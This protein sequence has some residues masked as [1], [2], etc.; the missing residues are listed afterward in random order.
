MST[1][2]VTRTIREQVTD[3]L[4][5]EVL[6]GKYQAG[7]PLRE[8]EVA[9]R[10]GVSRGPVRDAFL[11]LSQEGLLTYQ[12]NRGVTVRQP[13]L[14]EHQRLIVSLRRQIECYC[15][16]YGLERVTDEDLQLIA[17]ALKDLKLACWSEDVARV[18]RCDLQFHEAVLAACGGSQFLPIW[19]GLCSQMLLAYSRLATFDQVYEEHARIMD[20]LVRRSKP[21]A[22]AALRAN[23][24]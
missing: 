17:Q 9:R 8:A 19:R 22:I 4:R 23:I 10:F 15:I 24:R 21:D 1:A 14:P 16:R 18:A 2:G 12:A 3:R 11:Q 6:A 20:A 7:Q 13:P 5:E